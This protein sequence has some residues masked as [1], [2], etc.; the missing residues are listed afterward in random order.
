MKPSLKLLLV[1]AAVLVPNLALAQ[2]EDVKSL[3][4]KQ[5]SQNRARAMA[6]ELVSTILDV[7]MQQLKE[8]GLDELQ[9]YKDIKSM[10]KNI[11]GLIEA[12]MIEVVELLDRAQQGDRAEREEAYQTARTQIRKVVVTLAHERQKLALRLRTAEL[13]AQVKRLIELQTVA[14]RTTKTLPEQAQRE[15]EQSA[16]SVIEDQ[17]DVNGLFVLLVESL[18]A[19]REWSGPVGAG[20]GD[21]LQILKA[22]Q[23]GDNLDSAL[24]Q[25]Q[26]TKYLDAAEHQRQVIAVLRKLL[27]K[28]EEIQG[29]IGSDQESLLELI[30]NLKEEQNKLR[31]ETKKS[32][33]ADDDAATAL[34]Q[35]QSDLHQDLGK[36][37]AAM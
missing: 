37:S 6:H 27:E 33:P 8:N 26:A 11:S 1:L 31:V 2:V 13:A 5:E 7:Q 3:R 17:R 10:R 15:R 14:Y 16:L 28:V 32:D 30:R 19:I 21:G 12:E 22:G 18:S 25:I 36:L 4:R 29:L 20:A 24:R 35:K 34:A 23:A 9:I